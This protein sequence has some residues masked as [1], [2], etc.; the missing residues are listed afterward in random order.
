MLSV[1]DEENEE[2]RYK[3]KNIIRNFNDCIFQLWP[4]LNYDAH[5]EYGKLVSMKKRLEN[6]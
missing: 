6:R 4:K 2:E 3:T 5:K 1:K